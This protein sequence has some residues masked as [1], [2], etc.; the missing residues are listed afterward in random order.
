MRIL[1]VLLFGSFYLDRQTNSNPYKSTSLIKIHSN[2]QRLVDSLFHFNIVP[3]SC[4]GGIS[5]SEIIVDNLTLHWLN[6]KNMYTIH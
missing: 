5:E 2:N 3:I 6:K 1:G 4:R